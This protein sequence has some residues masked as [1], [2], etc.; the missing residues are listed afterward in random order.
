M[1]RIKSPFIS[2]LAPFLLISSCG[3]INQDLVEKAGLSEKLSEGSYVE[4]QEF[5]AAQTI[6]DLFRSKRSVFFLEKLNTIFKFSYSYNTCD[7]SQSVGE[8]PATLKDSKEGNLYFSVATDKP[9]H[10]VVETHQD[11]ELVDI[12]EK[13]FRNQKFL[14]TIVDG[15]TKYQYHF[16]GG[17]L[18]FSKYTANV[19]DSIVYKIENFTVIGTGDANK[20]D[21]LV[22]KYSKEENCGPG[23]GKETYEQTFQGH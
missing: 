14:N 15:A 20:D 1:R 18:G 23:E 16:F 6:C 5:Q 7:N 13:V 11:G 3:P 21:G 4:E 9:F 10:R 22:A 19:E 12:C 8:L 17:P 2:I